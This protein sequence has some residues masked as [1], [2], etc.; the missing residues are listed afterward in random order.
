MNLLKKKKQTSGLSYIIM[1][2]GYMDVIS[3]HKAGFDMAVASMGTSLTSVQAK[4]FKELLRAYLH[5]L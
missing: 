4:L 1:T 5:K 3:L 2:E